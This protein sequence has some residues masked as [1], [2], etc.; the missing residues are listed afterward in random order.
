V[1][2]ALGLGIEPVST[3]VIPRDRHAMFFATLGTELLARPGE[4]GDHVV[5]GNGLDGVDCIDI[6]LAQG[7]AV[8]G[9]ADRPCILGRDH[10]DPAHGF[11]CKYLDLPPDPVAVL[12]RPD[13]RHC[14]T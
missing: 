6:D 5:L 12:C 11:G 3:Q 10:S 4:K 7:V 13:G 9:F 14:G 2:A 8:I 1:A